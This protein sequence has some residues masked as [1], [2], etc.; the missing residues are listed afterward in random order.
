NSTA[1]TSLLDVADAMIAMEKW[2]GMIKVVGPIS[3]PQE[4]GFGF[5]KTDVELLKRFNRYLAQ[6]RSDGRYQELVD[7]YYPG[8]RVYFEPFFRHYGRSD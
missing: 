6:L 5:A 2:P 8:I 3:E 4:M 7:H 1:E